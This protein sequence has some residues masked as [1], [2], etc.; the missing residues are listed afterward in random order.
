MSY[1]DDDGNELNPDL[2]PK[3]E[4]CIRCR[5]DD[6]QEEEDQILCNLTRLDEV[7]EREFVCDAFVSK[8]P[9][10]SSAG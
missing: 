5:I 3:P 7:D 10:V 4:L 6:S 9:P 1:Y 8:Y 2:V